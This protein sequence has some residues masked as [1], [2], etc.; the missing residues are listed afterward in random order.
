MARCLRFADTEI[1]PTP[2]QLE[3]LRALG[4][5]HERNFALQSPELVPPDLFADIYKEGQS[6][7]GQT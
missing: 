6:R 2:V 1:F 7:H 4:R 3:R 5:R